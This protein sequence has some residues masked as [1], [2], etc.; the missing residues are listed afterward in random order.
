[1]IPCK[2]RR[3][4]VYE[5]KSFTEFI[6][7]IKDRSPLSGSQVPR[8]PGTHRTA[9]DIQTSKK[10]I[11]RKS[12]VRAIVVATALIV[13]CATAVSAVV[14]NSD[15]PIVTPSDVNIGFDGAD[16]HASEGAGRYSSTDEAV[17]GTVTD[18]EPP[19]ETDDMSDDPTDTDT[20][21]EGTEDGTAETI[22]EEVPDTK[23]DRYTVT[24]DFFGRDS[25]SCSLEEPATV[26]DIASRL[27]ITFE[28]SDSPNIPLDTVIS[29]NTTVTT[30]TVV[31]VVTTVSTPIAYTTV[32]KDDFN[33]PTGTNTV[34]VEGVNGVTV[35]EYEV[36]YVNGVEVSS[37]VLSTKTTDPVTKVVIRGC[38]PLNPGYDTRPGGVIDMTNDNPTGGSF[39]GGDGK[40]YTYTTYIDVMATIYYTGGICASGHVADET[41]I[42]VD[43]RVIP[44]GT[45][46]YITGEYA[47]IGYRTAEDTGGDIKGYKIDIC[48]DPNDPRAYNFGW[49]PM[50]V[51][52]LA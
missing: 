25:V 14:M 35:T 18:I 11:F 44:L 12:W 24:F 2:K 40:T 10:S 38:A 17:T 50:R 33:V 45:P 36:K 48:I 28:K 31:F 30:D 34:E 29:S 52:I 15:T 21:T 51:Y 9:S 8:N 16:I 13:C 39:V 22:P 19:A 26:A 7:G 42:A 3:F 32:Y 23:G 47:D 5:R 1:M 6:M 4:S 41:V 37:T 27:G 43:P 46:V 20:G 49:R